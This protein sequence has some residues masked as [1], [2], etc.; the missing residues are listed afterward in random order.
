MD[1]KDIVKELPSSSGV[2]LMKDAAGKIIYVGKAVSIRRRVQSYFRKAGHSG[3]TDLLVRDVRH[4]ECLETASEAEALILEA[5]LIKK[6]DPKYNV[7]LRDDKTYPVIEITGEDYPR[8]AVCRPRVR[9]AGAR[10]YGPYVNAVLV[11]DALKILRRIFYFRTDEKLGERV[12]LDYQIGLAEA[13]DIR[14]IDKKKYQGNIKNLCLI[15]EGKTDTL[16]R[17]LTREMEGLSRE[18]RFE[19]AA[20]VRDQLRAIG[21]LYSGTRDINYFKEAEQIKRAL[22][23]TKLPERIECFDIS[24]IMGEQAVGSMVSFWQGRPD[25]KQYRRFRIRDVKKIDDFGMIAEVVKRRY[26]RLRDE[27]QP[28]PDLV[29]VDGGKGQLSA[30][31][32]QLLLL[33]VQVPVCALAKRDEEIF[34]PGKRL[35]VVLKKDSLGLQ[36]LQRIRDEAHR[37]AVTYHKLLR[38]K[39]ALGGNSVTRGPEKEN[40][41]VV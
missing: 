28:Y 14:D 23:L 5:G 31:R 32:A 22:G 18:R 6:Y 10:Y 9:K 11:R 37:F 34:L 24:N 13:P 27:K 29:V 33:G 25:K 17:R 16:Y 1:L 40:P 39:A 2:Y 38:G 4:V 7:S 19:D 20:R 35:P 8:V 36:L 21:A 15:L 3:K 26:R 12:K 41:R 30:A